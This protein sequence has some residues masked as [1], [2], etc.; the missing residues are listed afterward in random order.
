MLVPLGYKIRRVREFKNLS[1]QYVAD[2]L[3]V[4]Q[5][6][7]SDMENGKIAVSEEKLAMIANVLDVSVDVINEYNDQV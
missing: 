2:K 6:T 1:Q 5:S 7:Y 4:S 3:S